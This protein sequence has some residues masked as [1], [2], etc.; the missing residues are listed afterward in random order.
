MKVGYVCWLKEV[1][2]NA[3]Y[4]PSKIEI[5]VEVIDY[6]MNN[7]RIPFVSNHW[8]FEQPSN[9]KKVGI[10]DQTNF[11]DWVTDSKSDL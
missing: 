7:A 9:H 11:T 6:F 10:K 5:T 1:W 4:F 8:S 2:I 3:V